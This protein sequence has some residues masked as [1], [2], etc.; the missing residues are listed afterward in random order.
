MESQRTEDHDSRRTPDLRSRRTVMKPCP[1]CGHIDESE[2]QRM[3]DNRKVWREQR[4][5]RGVCTTCG[6]RPA[7]KGRT[8]CMICATKNNAIPR[9]RAV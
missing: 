3:R 6:G 8:T 1:A 4:K 5:A 7:R 9:R 2:A